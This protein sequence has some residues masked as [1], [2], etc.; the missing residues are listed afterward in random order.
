M[1]G[2]Q[3]LSLLIL[4]LMISA[5]NEKVSPELTKG[6]ATVPD[7]VV[8]PKEYYFSVTNTSPTLLNF[9]LHKTGAGNQTA[10]CEIK[11]SAAFSSDNFRGN[12]AVN[13]ITCYFDAEELSLLHGGMSFSVNSSANSCDYIGY[14]PFSYYDRMPGD[15]SGSY[16]Q[17][18]CTTDTTTDQHA[19]DEA[20]ARGI[21]KAAFGGAIGC[22]DTVSTVIDP[23][24]RRRFAIADDS[25]LCQFNYERVGGG[26]CDIGTI[27]IQT[28]SVTFTPGVPPAL[29]TLKS[30]VTNRVV[31]CGGKVAACI[32]GPITE[33][34]R[35]MT[36]ATQINETVINEPFAKE[37]DLPALY[38]LEHE[39]SLKSYANFRRHLASRNI[40]YFDPSDGAYKSAFNPSFTDPQGID[41]KTFHPEVM[42]AYSKNKRLDGTGLELITTG[43]GGL[44]E[45]YSTRSN[46]YTAKPLAAE[47]FLGIPPY[48][49][50]PFYTFIC[51]DTAFDIKARIRMMVREWD[52]VTPSFN[53]HDFISDIGAGDS[54]ARQDSVVVHELN[55]DYDGHLLFND[56]PD[57]DDHIPMTRSGGNFNAGTIWQPVSEGTFL[58][59]WFNPKLFTNGSR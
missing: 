26:N 12:P 10:P 35:S 53:N 14:S 58:D 51:Y 23:I 45:T 55:G 46:T 56:L 44:L 21:E 59:G 24:T 15:S 19:R 2:T 8:P 20:D 39:S 52:R 34:T 29:D 11:G 6:E 47:P 30:T 17:V 22:G 32:A 4:S 27:N 3:K 9:N 54:A 40:N 43:S 33:L 49:T 1:K 28:L 50:N 42:D 36:K 48:T 13:D 25:D 7:V 57:W 18:E 5:C 31:S 38:N 41:A 37:Y 16:L